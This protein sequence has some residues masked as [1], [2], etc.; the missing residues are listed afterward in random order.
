MHSEVENLNF[1]TKIEQLLADSEIVNIFGPIFRKKPKNVYK[2]NLTDKPE[3]TKYDPS[4]IKAILESF[5]F[6]FAR[7]L[8]K[9]EAKLQTKIFL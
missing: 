3:A 1:T 2:S 8:S 4:T 7:H 5:L 6:C 9:F